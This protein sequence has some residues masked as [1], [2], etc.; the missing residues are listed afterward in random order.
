MF[1]MTDESD[2]VLMD[3]LREMGNIGAAHATTALSSLINRDIVVEVPEHLICATQQL[4]EVLDDPEQLVV[5]V[6]LETLGVS[7]GSIL[8]M[9]SQDMAMK[10]IIVPTPISA[11]LSLDIL[12]NFLRRVIC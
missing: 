10:M 7:K 3:G 11:R 8:L 9:F 6:F 5:G 4:P 12:A 1:S 2:P